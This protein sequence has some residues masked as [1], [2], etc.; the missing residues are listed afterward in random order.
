MF[1]KSYYL[2]LTET[3]LSN[4]VSPCVNMCLTTS[5][6]SVVNTLPR[7]LCRV[8]INH[9]ILRKIKVAICNHQA[10]CTFYLW[11]NV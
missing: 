8:L 1:N 4:L 6:S 7:A 9:K 2:G 11:G 3:C 10:D 5:A